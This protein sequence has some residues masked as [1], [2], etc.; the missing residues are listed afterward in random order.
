MG[1]ESFDVGAH[2]LHECAGSALEGGYGAAAFGA[3]CADGVAAV[4][5]VEDEGCVVGDDASAG[6]G[7]EEVAPPV[8]EG[9]GRGG[10]GGDEGGGSVVE[11]DGAAGGDVLGEGRA[12]AGGDGDGGGVA[13]AVECVVDEYLAAAVEDG[14]GWA[15]TALS[16]LE[17]IEAAG[18]LAGEPDVVLVGEGDGGGALG[19]G[20]AEQGH[21]AG[22]D[23]HVAFGVGADD[24]VRGE[25]G[26]EAGNDGGGGVGRSVVAPEQGPVD[27]RGG[28]RADALLCGEA[29]ELGGEVGAAIIGG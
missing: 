10:A 29:L 5:A 21:V 20:F 8:V 12:Q 14:G 16:F 27:G 17:L 25:V 1:L 11:H 22:G 18:E 19:E 15:C 28:L 7:D 3:G 26:G 6:G 13:D 4:L 24:P 2:D 23:A 9:G